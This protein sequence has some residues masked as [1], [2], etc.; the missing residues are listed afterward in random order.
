M[1]SLRYDSGSF[2]DKSLEEQHEQIT[3][4]H[5]S[6]DSANTRTKQCANKDHCNRAPADPDAP[7]NNLQPEGDIEV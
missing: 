7:M 1:K 6:S 4:V 5:A 2:G 3:I